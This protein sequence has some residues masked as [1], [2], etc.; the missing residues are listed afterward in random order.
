MTM[1]PL[2]NYLTLICT[3]ATPG[4]VFPTEALLLA[5]AITQED[6]NWI[7]TVKHSSEVVYVGPGP[8]ELMESPAPF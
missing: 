4:S 6:G 2:W 3:P 5:C 8:V 1:E 7:V